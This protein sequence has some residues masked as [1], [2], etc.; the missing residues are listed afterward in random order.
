MGGALLGSR[1]TGKAGSRVSGRPVQT[2]G[3]LSFVMVFLSMTAAPAGAGVTARAPQATAAIAAALREE[4]LVGAAWAT[5]GPDGS[6]ATGAA[7][8]KD[9]RSRAPLRPDHKVHIGSITKTLVATGVLRLVSEGRVRLDTPVAELLPDV[10]FD[11]PWAATDPVRV[12]HLL[13]HTSGLDD[14]RL[15]Q[16]FSRNALPDTPLSAS[17]AGDPSLLRIRSRPGSTFSYSNMGYTLLGR[18]IETATGERYETYL[19]RQLLG[20]LGMTDSSFRFVSQAGA[21]GDARL[22]MGHFEQGAPQA[23]VPQYLRPAGQ[24]TTTA[25]DMA[26]FARFL[27]GDGDIGGERFIDATLLRAMGSP[28][29][30]DAALAG[31]RAGYGLGLSRR[32]R[33]GVVG[34]CH[35]GSTVGYRAML[36]LYPGDRKAFFIALNADSEAADYGRFDELLVR[37]LG[38]PAQPPAMPAAFP[39]DLETWQGIYVPSPNRFQTFAYL[40]EV[41]GFATVRR[42]GGRLRLKPF[43][44]DARELAPVGGALFRAS[45]RVAASHVLLTTRDGEKV[46]SDGFQSFRKIDRWQIGLL[47]ASLAAGV[48]GL[49]YVLLAGLLRATTRS[50]TRSSPIFYPWLAILAAFLPLPLFLTQSFLQLGDLTLASGSL[51]LASGL[52]PLALIYGVVRRFRTGIANW[53]ERLESIAMVGAL[54]WTLVLAAWGL[55]PITL[56]A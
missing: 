5:L 21:Q 51:A 37:A 22:A 18:T 10:R 40:D 7:G 41:L 8:F 54:Q 55:M 39:V 3:V 52:L 38:I 23:A 53:T 32:D 19:D 29:G 9:A 42:E 46:I 1:V 49:G 15:W 24:F 12:R 11:N 33:S 14:A 17:F 35:G 56:W 45:D 34:L 30:T 27:L 25:R 47:W 48:T 28:A 26:L 36:C 20:P 13:D 44:S 6:I 2:L 43:Q 50:L 4:G 16:V 31:L